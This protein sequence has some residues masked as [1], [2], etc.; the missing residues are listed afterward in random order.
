MSYRKP[1][2]EHPILAYAP[3][4]VSE[5]AGRSRVLMRPPERF[6]QVHLGVD[7]HHGRDTTD[8]ARIPTASGR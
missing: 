2:S 8:A 3:D 4:P 6:R 5:T 7:G 1:T